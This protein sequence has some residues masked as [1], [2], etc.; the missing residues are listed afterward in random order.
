[1][2]DENDRDAFI[3]YRLQQA[4]ETVKII[5]RLVITYLSFQ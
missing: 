4:M 2:I 3:A 5:F 1:M